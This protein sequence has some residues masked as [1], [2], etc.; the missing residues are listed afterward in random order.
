MHASLGELD[1]LTLEI[2][3]VWYRQHF[4]GLSTSYFALSS[5]F[6]GVKNDLGA[7]GSSLV[8]RAFEGNGALT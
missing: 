8:W 1:L 7:E 6:W 2:N 3:S 4:Y 5:E